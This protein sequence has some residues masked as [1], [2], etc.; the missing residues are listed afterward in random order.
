MDDG[1]NEWAANKEAA[2]HRYTNLNS[3]GG[4]YTRVKH[5]SI[6]LARWTQMSEQITEENHRTRKKT[7]AGTMH[8][9]GGP[10]ETYQMRYDKMPEMT[11][12]GKR[13]RI[14]KSANERS[15]SKKQRINLGTVRQR[16]KTQKRI[17]SSRTLQM[18]TL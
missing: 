16:K 5:R 2:D 10:S 17:K 3:N 14:W 7:V 12:K 1:T 8:N 13:K 11:S 4:S 6:E 15:R 9:T 18:M